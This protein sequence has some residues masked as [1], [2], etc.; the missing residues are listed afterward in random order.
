[1]ME[2]WVFDR[3]GAFSPGPFNIHGEPLKFA[4]AFVG[5]ATMEEEAMGLDMFV[6][7][8]DGHREVTLNDTSGKETRVRLG[9]LMVKQ[10]AIVCRGTTCYETQNGYVARFAWAS[11]KRK[12]EVEH[13]NQAQEKGVKG[14]AKVVSSDH[15]HC[16]YSGGAGFLKGSPF[17][18]RG[19]IS[20]VAYEHVKQTQRPRRPHLHL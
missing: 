5:Y 18:G 2:P 4:R 8:K 12:Q 7:L 9:E 17:S 6:E 3:S 16:R 1:M 19:T 20:T 15:C 10:K 13:L 11:D 14:V